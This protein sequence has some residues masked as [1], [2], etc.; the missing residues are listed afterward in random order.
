MMGWALSHACSSSVRTI[1]VL[2]AAVTGAGPKKSRTKVRTVIRD[3]LMSATPSRLF[4]FLGFAFL[5][6]RYHISMW[7]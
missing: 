4:P 1:P 3:L 7:V 2:S 5:S 6:T